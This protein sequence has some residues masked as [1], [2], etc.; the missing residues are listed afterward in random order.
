[1]YKSSCGSPRT[2]GGP[3]SVAI[4]DA[5]AF[6]M[7]HK[8]VVCGTDASQLL[9]YTQ[10]H[11]PLFGPGVGLMRTTQVSL[12]YCHEQGS[13]FQTRFRKLRIV[14]G[15]VFAILVIGAFTIFSEPVRLWF[16]WGAKPGVVSLV[17]G[18]VLFLF[19]GITIFC[20]KPFLYDAFITRFGNGMQIKSCSD[21]FIKNVIEA[22]RAIA[23]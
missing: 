20:I 15:V 14:Q 3:L 23:R 21:V 9:S 16:G 13:A 11:L 1:M 17:F 5:N 12:P 2:P 6:Q 10:D 7:P 18:G 19:L 22:N 8:C 4:T